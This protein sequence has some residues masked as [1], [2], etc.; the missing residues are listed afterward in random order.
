MIIA[1]SLIIWVK[2]S[3]IYDPFFLYV[4][5]KHTIRTKILLLRNKS[6]FNLAIDNGF[7]TQ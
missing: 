2:F 1:F 4:G 7:L 6:H 3:Q 5:D